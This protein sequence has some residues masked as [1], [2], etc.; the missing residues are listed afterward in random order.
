MR[1][2]KNNTEIKIKYPLREECDYCGSELEVDE[3]DT[4][5][6]YLGAIHYKCPVCGTENMIDDIDG[7]TLTKDNVEFPNHFHHFGKGVDLTSDEI[8]KYINDAI[9]YFRE[10]PDSFCYTTGAG[11]TGILVQNFSGD[12]EYHVV[13]TKDF[14]DVGIPYE[15]EDY[16]AL[17]S[18]DGRWRNIG[19]EAWRELRKEHDINK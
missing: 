3:K 17:V 16:K 18:V 6:G 5:V 7:L 8:R 11:N 2:I 1:V 4:Y 15:H 14:Y 9:E 13:V 10:N 12:Y 19:I